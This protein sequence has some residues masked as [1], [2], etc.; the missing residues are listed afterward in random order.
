[1]SLYAEKRYE[2][3]KR[4]REKEKD[5][6]FFQGGNKLIYQSGLAEIVIRLP[7]PCYCKWCHCKY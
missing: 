4:Q 3:R 2:F 6:P 1:M 5:K 7:F